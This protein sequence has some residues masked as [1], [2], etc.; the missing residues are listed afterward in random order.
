MSCRLTQ[1]L[2]A[3]AD[4][5]CVFEIRQDSETFQ[6]GNLFELKVVAN[7]MVKICVERGGGIG[8]IARTL[9]GLNW[10][11]GCN[12]LQSSHVSKGGMAD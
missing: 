9:G 6:Y 7:A 11:T 1:D 3:T 5:K 10:T 12:V 4:G 8:G 2:Y